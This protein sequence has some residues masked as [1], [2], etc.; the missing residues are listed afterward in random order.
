MS[1]DK[2]ECIK[3]AAGTYSWD[4]SDTTCYTCP[5]GAVCLGIAFTFHNNHYFCLG[6]KHLEAQMNYYRLP[7]S[8]GV[9][10]TSDGIKVCSL[11]RCGIDD[12]CYGLNPLSGTVTITFSSFILIFCE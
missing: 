10:Y 3:C 11:T 7:N 8:E 1:T 12:L 6:G 5:T 4:T 2:T 9:C